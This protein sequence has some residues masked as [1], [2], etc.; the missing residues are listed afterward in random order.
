MESKALSKKGTKPGSKNSPEK[1]SG[2]LSRKAKK[3]AYL[4][5]KQKLQAKMQVSDPADSEEKEADR[6]AADVKRN[7]A[8]GNDSPTTAAR[9]VGSGSGSVSRAEE[10]EAQTKL[11]RE[12][13]EEAAQT[14][15][16]RAEEEEAQT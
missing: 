8:S 10:E 5:K 3:P 16:M 7:L 13:E 1:S 2:A 15:L 4:Q 6:V 14:K 11:Y 12:E 9:S